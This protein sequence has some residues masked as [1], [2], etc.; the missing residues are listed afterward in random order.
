MKSEMRISRKEE[1]EEKREMEGRTL[2]EACI[3][4]GYGKQ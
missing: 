1:E 4:K 3:H 2:G